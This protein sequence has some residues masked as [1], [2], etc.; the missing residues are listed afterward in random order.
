MNKVSTLNI[1]NVDFILK[2]SELRNTVSGL[3]GEINDTNEVVSAAL[4]DLN[5]RSETFLT[6]DD[7]PYI[8]EEVITGEIVGRLHRDDVTGTGQITIKGNSGQGFGSTPIATAGTYTIVIYSWSET[9]SFGYN[10]VFGGNSYTITTTDGTISDKRDFTVSAD[11]LW[12]AS[13]TQAVASGTTLI[14]EIYDKSKL[15]PVLSVGTVALTNLYDDLD[16]KPTL[17]NTF[18]TINDEPIT[19]EGNIEMPTVEELDD[20]HETIS[21]S[22][23]D[24][25]SRLT[26]LSGKVSGLPSG[27]ELDNTHE[28]I[29]T[30]INDLTD[31]LEIVES[32]NVVI[33]NIGDG[34]T[35]TN[36]TSNGHQIN[37]EYG[38]INSGIQQ[39]KLAGNYLNVVGDT[40]V[41]IPLATSGI[42]GAMSA[43]DK[44]KLDNTIETVII[45]ILSNQTT[46]S[47]DDYDLMTTALSDGKDVKIKGWQD[48]NKT[49]H[50]IYD[51]SSSTSTYIFFGQVTSLVHRCVISKTT[52]GVSRYSISIPT[53]YNSTITLRKQN[54]DTIGYFTTQEP[55]NKSITIPI[56]EY[57]DKIEYAD[58]NLYLKRDNG[59]VNPINH[60]DLSTQPSILPERFGKKNIYEVLIAK[61]PNSDTYPTGTTTYFGVDG[62]DSEGKWV[63]FNTGGIVSNDAVIISASIFGEGVNS[64]C[65]MIKDNNTWKV[66]PLLPVENYISNFEWILLK[67]Y[68][69]QNAYYYGVGTSDS[70]HIWEK[71]LNIHGIMGDILWSDLTTTRYPTMNINTGVVP[72]GVCICGES[73]SKSGKSI[74]MALKFPEF[75]ASSLT[76]T[77]TSSTS[78]NS[79][80][81][82]TFFTT[83]RS[84]SLLD[85]YVTGDDGFNATQFI[86]SNNVQ[87][88]Y[89]AFGGC[90]YYSTLGTI[91]GD[92]YLG[93]TEDWR[94]GLSNSSSAEWFNTMSS[95]LT[96]LNNN[97]PNDCFSWL[98]FLGKT[99]S[100]QATRTIWAANKDSGSGMSSQAY[101]IN[102]IEDY[103]IDTQSTATF[104]FRYP[105]IPL[106]QV[107]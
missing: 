18:K 50:I 19:G 56:P 66:Y 34:N 62:T 102:I 54:N 72:I 82:I 65:S 55:S 52:R 87:E 37:V 22:L 1:N 59:D 53:V 90:L 75:S 89:P 16:G 15:T 77:H 63:C 45:E 61:N 78:W 27:D 107:S 39:L 57:L 71:N 97:Y 44:Q 12:S 11:A 20:I 104:A 103:T 58:D 43:S 36:I 70:K 30:S 64:H 8:P 93:S 21:T 60:P 84:D 46:L 51:Y 6:E 98:D 4:N 14:V 73:M 9:K 85:E 76:P 95:I 33:N 94:I 92:W 88:S 3:I 101:V 5:T 83:N 49:S 48:T 47:Q 42:N 68:G 10:V 99:S 91:E 31:R 79:N 40:E 2:D 38:D 13:V 26:E 7:I 74:F 106:I 69:S 86:A 100:D 17:P 81:N 29:S 24:L 96:T 28:I 32:K 80:T 23:N 41:N 105:V 25:N 35:I 67:Y